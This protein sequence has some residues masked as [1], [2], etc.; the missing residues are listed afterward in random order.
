MTQKED[1]RPDIKWVTGY[2][3]GLAKKKKSR[4]KSFISSSFLK[5]SWNPRWA[6]IAGFSLCAIFS[7]FFS[8]CQKISLEPLF[9]WPISQLLLPFVPPPLPPVPSISA[10][11]TLSLL[12]FSIYCPPSV[13]VIRRIT[14]DQREKR[15]TST[16]DLS[17]PFLSP[18][19]LWAGIAFSVLSVSLFD[20]V[21]SAVFTAV[22]A[23]LTRRSACKQ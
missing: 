17:P 13:I 1:N 2:S 10:N 18:F 14:G 6:I 16:T 19:S 12:T 3:D 9:F 8:L 4:L 15:R 20:I 11:F 5:F 7:C 23:P 22:T 21:L